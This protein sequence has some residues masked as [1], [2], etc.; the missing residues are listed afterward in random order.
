MLIPAG[1]A[2]NPELLRL[3]RF[4]RAAH[5]VPYLILLRMGFALQPGISARPG[6]LLHRLFTLVARAEAR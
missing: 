5:A 4:G 6:G 1:L 3:K 2:I